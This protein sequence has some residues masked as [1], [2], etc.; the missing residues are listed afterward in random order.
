M[1]A[2]FVPLRST[3]KAFKNIV[4]YLD[5]IFSKMGHIYLQRRQK[6]YS[7]HKTHFQFDKKC[8]TIF[9]DY[10]ITL[11]VSDIKCLMSETDT[12]YR[13]VFDIT[14]DLLCRPDCLEQNIQT[15]GQ[16]ITGAKLF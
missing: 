9:Y 16:K 11:F 8:D 12:D 14:R 15:D 1:N 5:V 6:I 10:I 4:L 3:Q 13:N 2:F 7:F